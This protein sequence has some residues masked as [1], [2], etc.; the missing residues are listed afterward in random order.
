[1]GQRLTRV[2]ELLR[3]ELSLQ[4]HTTYKDDAVYVTITEV[5]VSPDLR[6][7]VVYYSVLGS[8]EHSQKA[9]RFFGRFA[10]PLRQS[11]SKMVKLKYTP[12][13]KF[14]EDD[15]LERGHRTVEL[16]EDLEMDDA[17]NESRDE[18]EQQAP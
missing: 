9:R 17:F 12:F 1:M 14:I 5:D 3:R 4:L 18:G 10:A 13:L 2:N 16:M 7:G 11:V 8:E 15:S 6:T